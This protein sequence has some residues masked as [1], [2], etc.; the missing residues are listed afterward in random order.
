[1]RA[2]HPRPRAAGLLPQPIQVEPEGLRDF[3]Q[4]LLADRRLLRIEPVVELPEATLRIRRLRH[5]SGEVGAR[6]RALVR[7]VAEDVR[8]AFA[9]C[10]AQSG[11]HVPEVPTVRAEV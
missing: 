7:K 4:P 5:A 3:E 2:A 8:E 11:E 6:M 9:E 10:L 1:R